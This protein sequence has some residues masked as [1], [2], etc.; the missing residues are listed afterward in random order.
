M[1]RPLPQ[2]PPEKLAKAEEMLDDGCSFREITKTL[3]MSWETLK[4]YFP[5]R[6]WTHQ[7][8]IEHGV[9]VRQSNRAIRK[10]Q[11]IHYVGAK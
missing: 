3:N 5:G 9:L 6:Q 2:I 10:A 1:A 8:C 4:R 11:G 7:Q